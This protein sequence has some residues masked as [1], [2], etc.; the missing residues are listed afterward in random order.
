MNL[1]QKTRIRELNDAFRRSFDGGRVMLTTGVQSLGGSELAIL[2]T[3]VRCFEEFGAGNDPHQE[4]DFG[5]VEIESVTYFWKID[6]YDREQRCGSE[7][8]SDPDQTT[9]VLTIMQAAEY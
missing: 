6:Y 8:P 9:R 7:D 1:D 2:L 4:H 5:S 3:R